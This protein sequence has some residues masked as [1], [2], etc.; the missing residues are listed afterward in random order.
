MEVWLNIQYSIKY[1]YEFAVQY[2][3]QYGLILI[4]NMDKN[5]AHKVVPD[6]DLDGR[7]IERSNGI[8]HP[9]ATESGTILTLLFRV[10]TFLLVSRTT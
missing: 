3:Y 9:F 1:Q 2:Q 7:Q 6:S 8:P 5:T 10:R 4:L